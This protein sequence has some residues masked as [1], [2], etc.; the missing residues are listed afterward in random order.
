MKK[1]NFRN[2]LILIRKE[3]VGFVDNPAT[4][5]VG[6]VFLLI[7][8][9]LF[10]RNVFVIGESSLATLFNLFPWISLIF[11]PALT[12]GAISK[13]KD[14]GTLELILTHPVKIW[15]LVLSKF[16]STFLF[17]G[18]VLLFTLP[19]AIS[20][21][22]Y[23]PLDWGIYAS[24]II[25]ALFF[26]AALVSL[27]IFIS[28]LFSSQIASLLLTVFSGF[29]FV[30]FGTELVTI[31]LPSTVGSF[32]EKFSLANHY[33]A[34]SRGILT[35]SDIL[36]FIIFVA[37][38]LYEANLQI[39]KQKSNELKRKLFAIQLGGFLITSLII[40]GGVL[41]IINLRLDITQNK[42]YT[43]SGATKKVLLELDTPVT[44]T[45]YASKNLPAQ[46]APILRETQYVLEDYKN[47]SKS[48][49]IYEQKDPSVSEDEEQKALAS[50]IQRAQ[51]NIIGQDEL[52]SKEGYLGITINSENRTEAIPFIQGTA[53]L[54]YEL[55]TLI[56]KLTSK[57]KKTLGFLSGNNEKSIYDDYKYLN[58]ELSKQFNLKP[59]FLSDEIKEIDQ[60]I[61]VLIIAGPTEP[62]EVET[63][64]AVRTYLNNG[65]SV[66]FLLDKILVN[67]DFTSVVINHNLEQ[68]L[69]E[70]G[71]TLRQDVIYDLRAY[72]QLNI[73]TG[74]NT[75]ALN[76]PFWIR[77]SISPLAQILKLKTNAVSLP[78]ASSITFDGGKAKESGYTIKP[79]L[80][81]SDYGGVKLDT[82]SVLPDQDL[83]A[84]KLG[85]I[86]AGVTMEPFPDTE[87]SKGRV[88][89]ITDS[90]FLVDMF[91]TKIPSNLAFGLDMFS[92]VSQVD[93]FADIQVKVNAASKF[94]FANST[95][96]SQIRYTVMGLSTGLPILLAIGRFLRRRA[97]RFQNYKS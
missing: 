96:P 81:T 20:F 30:V 11:I 37:L 22:N 33:N 64:S 16:L 84:D 51:F 91:L 88:V 50:G 3:L 62:L 92:W 87:N 93:S 34:L 28:S 24:Q 42:I 35:L 6:I 58:Q 63:I 4:Y 40:A 29:I 2:I 19:L 5:V 68:I 74:A 45:L 94:T 15:E 10:F 9:F 12:M 73:Q 76:Y 8:E 95:Q 60:N 1:I 27:G 56:Y 38:F 41:S 46:Y 36:F 49:I 32:L 66:V 82:A 72:E 55:T 14:D 75:F 43:L 13:E 53:D 47:T 18:V 70:Y 57:D 59:V 17:V 39:F 77:T 89:V 48:K 54:E 31:S 79:L 44:L 85:K 65:G 78:W 21:N 71:V 90:E 97:L 67:N 69:E 61:H 23:G 83:P 80:N 86:T 25:G 52:Q 7:W 26:S